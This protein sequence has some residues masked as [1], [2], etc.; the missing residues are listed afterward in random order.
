[1]NPGPSFVLAMPKGASIVGAFKGRWACRSCLPD[2]T[3]SLFLGMHVC[4][5]PP[6]LLLVP[7]HAVINKSSESSLMLS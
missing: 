5:R 1:M 3:P 2:G 7:K 6:P 4:T